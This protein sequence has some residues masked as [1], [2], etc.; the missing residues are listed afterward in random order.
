M[1][2]LFAELLLLAAIS[3]VKLKSLLFVI[4]TCSAALGLSSTGLS[5]GK[6]V[7]YTCQVAMVKS[8]GSMLQPGEQVI[9]ALLAFSSPESCRDLQFF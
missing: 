7:A 9:G 8:S 4:S 1:A 2:S 5:N 3:F 6:S